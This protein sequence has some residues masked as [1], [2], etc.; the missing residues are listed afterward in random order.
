MR[1]LPT[2]LNWLAI[3]AVV[4]LSGVFYGAAFYPE[5]HFYIGAIFALT[6][7]M[8]VLV[9][10]RGLVLPGLYYRVHRLPTPAYIPIALMIDLA[11]ISV[12]YA[13]SGSLLKIMGITNTSW[14][15]ATILSAEVL[16]Y[17]LSVTALMVFIMRV[18]ELLG[19]D[20]FISLLT[21]RYRNPVPEERVFLFIDLV[22][23]TAFAEQHG[24]LRTQQYLGSLF[25]TFAEQIR[26][27]N[28]AIDDYIGDAAIVTWPL[29]RGIKNGCCVR[30]IFDIFANIEKNK[31]VWL[32][33]YGQVPRL[34]AALHGGSVITAEIGVDR[35]KITYFGDTVNTTARLEGLS[36]TLERHVLIS[37]DLADLMTLPKGIHAEY[38]GNHAVKGRGRE[39][40]VVALTDLGDGIARPP[41]QLSLNLGK[42]S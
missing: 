9:F 11:L 2:A 15:E 21:G 25:G 31:D 40:G 23:S 5:S 26:R 30:C 34:R 41:S 33:V 35:H 10:E 20:V 27:H 36:K 16:V 4:A 37:S 17:A 14:A 12:G 19:R 32:K 28:G 13:I 8:P 39:V 3:A 24:D 29:Q 38:L 7:G 1:T 42:A 18:R 6:T 22:G